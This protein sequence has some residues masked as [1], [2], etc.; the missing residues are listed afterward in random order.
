MS[1]IGMMDPSMFVGRREVID[2]INETLQINIDKIEQ[3]ASG[4]IACQLLDMM[5]P[6]TIPMHKVDWAANKDFEFIANYKVLQN[7]FI[8]HDV[9][10]AV[11]VNRLI[12]GRYQDNFEFMQW[13]KRFFEMGTS[14]GIGDYDPVA[15]RLK[16]R[17]GQAYNDTYGKLRSTTPRPP[18]ASNQAQSSATPRPLIV[19]SEAKKVKNPAAK[20]TTAAPGKASASASAPVIA[21]QPSNDKKPAISLG[22]QTASDSSLHA[23]VAELTAANEELKNTK[24]EMQMEFDRIEKERDFYFEKLRDIEMMLQDLEDV[25]EGNELTANI[26]KILYAT[27][28]GFQP[29]GD[30]EGEGE[31]PLPSQDF[32][33]ESAFGTF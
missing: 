27:A 15:Q 13:Y 31:E 25:G 9:A 28:D 33:G 26:F 20:T 10:R 4:A 29:S 6:G 7:G 18:K 19:K 22:N 11:D 1:N 2:W 14:G 16:G 21:K 23:Q 8:R 3:T 32:D 5:H 30:V 24:I 17:G 12:Q